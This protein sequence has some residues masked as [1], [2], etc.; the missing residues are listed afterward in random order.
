MEETTLEGSDPYYWR[1]L[2]RGQMF[3]CGKV[4]AQIHATYR[5]HVVLYVI[6]ISTEEAKT[7]LVQDNHIQGEQAKVKLN[8]F[9]WSSF[10]KVFFMFPAQQDILDIKISLSLMETTSI[11]IT[12]TADTKPFAQRLLEFLK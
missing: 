1:Y 4:T 8:G 10:P 11:N 12:P 7:Q 5:I 3:S 2:S 6:F 9:L